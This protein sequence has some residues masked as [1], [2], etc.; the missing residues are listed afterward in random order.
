MRNAIFRYGFLLLFLSSCSTLPAIDSQHL[1][2]SAQ[3]VSRS[4]SSQP[5]S[6][7]CFFTYKAIIQ[8][9]YDGD[10]VTADIDL[11]FHTWI[12]GEKLRLARINAPELKG[13]ERPAGLLARDWLRKQI[14]G[15]SVIIRTIK[16]KKGKYGRY[17]AEIIL[18]G[19]NIND[20]L[21]RN[22][23]AQYKDY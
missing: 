16:D 2:D 13:D 6:S 1:P 5:Q 20:A 7:D 8:S 11:G 21:V 17:I 15:K 18:N 14:L 19:N 9:V 3:A 4:Y 23:Y 10:T 22:G 12:H